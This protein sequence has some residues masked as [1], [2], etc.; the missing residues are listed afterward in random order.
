MIHPFK[1]VLFSLVLLHVVFVYSVY[2]AACENSEDLLVTITH[3]E[4]LLNAIENTR[5]KVRSIQEQMQG[6]AGVGREKEL[7]Q[8][9]SRFSQ[10][11]KDL[12]ANFHQLATDVHFDSFDANKKQSFDWQ[13]EIKELIEPLFREVKQ[14]TSHP[15]Q[16]DALETE[17]EN[18]QNQLQV[19]SRANNR[20]E[21]I[22]PQVSNKK[23]HHEIDQLR[24]N[25]QNRYREV[26]TRLDITRQKLK[27]KTSQKKHLSEHMHELMQL[28]F[29]SR[30][31]NFILALIAF[32]L[33]WF[34]MHQL[35][36]RIHETRPFQKQPRP[37]YIRTF[38]LIYW[39]SSFLISLVTLLVV[40]YLCGD[41]FLLS[42]CII[43]IVGI[44]WASNHALPKY[45]K[46]A[47]II[48][49]LGPVR[50]GELVVYNGISY[51]VSR[52]NLASELTNDQLAGGKIQLPLKDLID[53]R[54]RPI[55]M[56]E[57]WFPTHCDDYVL[58]PDKSL[59]KI[60]LQTPDFVRVQLIGGQLQTFTTDEFLKMSIINLSK[61]FRI[62]ARVHFDENHQH[63][64][65]DTM[66]ETL[67][68]SI[69]A[70]IALHP[71]KD[72]L[73]SVQT[74]VSGVG[75]NAFQLKI[76]TT[77]QGAASAYYED[78]EHVIFST[79]IQTCN[80][81]QWKISFYPARYHQ[82]TQQE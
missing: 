4:E 52:I 78:I 47:R 2:E 11:L 65:I 70:E 63:R 23:L 50:E 26:K 18:L 6:T 59:G 16:I 58:M 44:V 72:H 3:L 8:Q 74:F 49:N 60:T 55:A 28:F 31:R 79:C 19:A 37:V 42:L 27:Q 80:K 54:S 13:G 35:Q 40:L 14:M 68:E 46:Q 39:I 82:V 15:R 36:V 73:I 66:I 21:T 7:K 38:D 9:I 77:F 29:R 51:R 10:R 62:V 48:L 57:C 64:L 34:L 45:W 53:I 76:M 33:T 24:H 75:P 22:I 43:I 5:H 30:G 56:N 69:Q 81:N 61:G 1:K 25:W 67:S 41:W 12:E 17:I 71:F 32:A 20:L